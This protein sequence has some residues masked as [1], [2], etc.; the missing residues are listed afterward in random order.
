M[1]MMAERDTVS[2]EDAKKM[3]YLTPLER[4]EWLRNQSK[5][6]VLSDKV[7]LIIGSYSKFL[8]K[9]DAPKDKLI[10][11][12]MDP[13]ESSGARREAKEFGDN[14]HSLLCEMGRDNR[15]FR[16]LVV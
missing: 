4:L 15:L 9:T 5:F 7:N 1:A 3:V 13:K 8:E 11:M 10:E 16:I 12:F 2:E 6:A 14:V